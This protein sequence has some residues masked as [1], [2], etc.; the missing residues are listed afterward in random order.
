MYSN[1]GLCRNLPDICAAS[2]SVLIGTGNSQP[3]PYG[4]GGCNDTNDREPGDSIHPHDR[5]IN[6]QDKAAHSIRYQ[7]WIPTLSWKRAAQTSRI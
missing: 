7:R 3:V 2:Q 5:V 1:P 4:G 6:A